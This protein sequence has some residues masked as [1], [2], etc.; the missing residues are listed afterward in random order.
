MTVAQRSV[1]NVGNSSGEK[2]VREKIK[3]CRKSGDAGSVMISCWPLYEVM[4]FLRETVRHKRLLIF[5][6][7]TFGKICRCCYSTVTNLTN[8]QP[9]EASQV[10]VPVA[11]GGSNEL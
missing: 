1:Q 6:A 3:K 11:S 7:S 8:F 9:D 10:A 5:C 2:Y 4:D